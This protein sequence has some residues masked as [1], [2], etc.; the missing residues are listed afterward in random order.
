[1][2][3][4]QR[5][6][7]PPAGA[8]GDLT[9]TSVSKRFDASPS[10][11]LD[12]V[13][14]TVEKGGTVALLGESGSG[15]TT[16]LRLVAGFEE[17][18]SGTIG[19]GDSLIADDRHSL[20]PED[21]SVG[22]VFQDTALLPHLTLRQNIAFGLHRLPEQKRQRRLDRVI[23]LVRVGESQSRYPHQV[24]GGQAQRAAIA[25]AL[26][27][28]PRVLLLDEPLNNLDGPHRTQL[29]EELRTIL[30]LRTTTTIFVTHDR[31]E[32]FNIADQVVVLRGGQVQ[33]TGTPEELYWS[34]KTPFV[35]SLLGKTNLLQVHRNGTNWVSTL[36]PIGPT[37]PLETGGQPLASIRPSQICVSSVPVKSTNQQ[38][39]VISSR[40]LGE[41]R[42]LT[43]ALNTE[44]ELLEVIAH[45]T[46]ATQ[47]K[48]GDRVF[49]SI[50]P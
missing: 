49:M 36:G 30:A 1:M 50:I 13:S 42:E 18:D 17:P 19:I 44:G 32:A 2:F 11:A 23:E 15:K 16:V 25:R 40:F 6:R 46:A 24:S 26:A 41:L 31:D 3:R 9:L 22:V 14:L 20:P 35:A 47:F 12:H 7:K 5:T 37:Q 48:P 21:R 27:P 34:P 10:P 33:Q 8:G 38:G 43:I 28:R 39:T 45:T 4:I 29:I